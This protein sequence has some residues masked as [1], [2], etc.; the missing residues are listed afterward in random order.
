MIYMAHPYTT[1]HVQ[2]Q[3]LKLFEPLKM[4]KKWLFLFFFYCCLLT[5]KKGF[6]IPGVLPV[7]F[8]VGSSVEVKAVKLTSIR[9][10]MPYDYYYLPFC[11]PDGELQYKS[12]N[13]GEILRGD[14]IVNTPFALNM[15]IPVKCALLCA[16]N[17]VKTKLSAAESDLL[18]EKIRNEYRVH[19]LIDNLPGTT[20]TQLENGRDA[21][22]HGYALGFWCVQLEFFSTETYRIVGFEIQARSLSSMQYVPDS[23]KSC[24]WNS[25]SEAQP[26]KPGVVNEIYWSYSAE[27][28]LSPIRWASR[29]DS[30][31]SMRSNQIHWLSI[32]N[33]IV[34]VVFLAG[35]L[36]LIIM[37]TVRRDIAYYNRLDESL[38]DT[39]EESGWKLVHGDI[40]RPPRR[41]TLLVCVLGTGI[42]LLGM[43][44][45]TLAFAMVGMLSPSSR[46]ALMSVAFLFAG[47]FAGRMYKTLRLSNWK[48][49][50]L[51]VLRSTA[52]LFPTFLF[53][54]GL[55]LNI[56]VW[57]NKSS[58]TVPFS[59]IM[60]LL[61]MFFCIDIPLVMIGFRFGFRKKPYHH[62]V[63]TNQIPRQVPEQPFYSN[64]VISILF[65][66]ILPFLA[67]F[68][69][70]FFIFT[71]M[72]QNQFYYLFGFL[73]IVFIILIISTALMSIL[74]IYFLL[75][76]ENYHWWWR[77]FFVGGSS[78][79]YVFAYSI[80]YAATKLEIVGVTP[81][82]L[83]FGYTILISVTFWILTGTVGFY[84]SSCLAYTIILVPFLRLLPY[85]THFSASYQ[86]F[87]MAYRFFTFSRWPKILIASI[88]SHFQFHF[89]GT[90]PEI[91]NT[92]FN[93]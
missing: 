34:I 33:S 55:I 87:E 74:I 1:M 50:S 70:L 29:W 22:M 25:E 80:Y 47:Y 30:Y 91:A 52:C 32:V 21:Y 19:L 77:S 42:Q 26:L 86:I 82:L 10:Q 14:R 8:H 59:S 61:S 66:G 90:F 60:S 88:N 92:D 54:V 78:A 84:A 46:G 53:V 58:G 2:F 23:G 44:L 48:S 68:L 17:N 62:P 13:L 43:A 89:S 28:R 79:F 64:V 45:V 6:Y 41:A 15:D 63:R 93:Q 57:E 16:K 4:M 20:K 71:A 67:M 39:M 11:L 24:S 35:F 18:I 38:D 83:Y 27:W 49:A 40:F 65:S 69:E 73:F 85:V 7:E 72:W 36:G 76:V 9:T 3:F 31:L 56:L 12:E 37:R 5:A 75:A 51:K 81:K